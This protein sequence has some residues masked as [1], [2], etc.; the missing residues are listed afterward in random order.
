VLTPKDS[1]FRVTQRNVETDSNSTAG[2]VK[3]GES[4]AKPYS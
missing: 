3:T 2:K 4:T 1:Q